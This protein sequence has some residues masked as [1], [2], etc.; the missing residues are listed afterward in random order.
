MR[1]GWILLGLL[2]S[3]FWAWSL[4]G[5]LPAKPPYANPVTFKV[6]EAGV[7]LE[8]AIKAAAKTA[9]VPVLLKGVPEVPVSVDLKK[10][11]F[12]RF[13]DLMLKVYAPELDYALLPEGVVLI[14][15]KETIAQIA[16]PPKPK[17]PEVQKAA[18]KAE[19]EGEMAVV[20]DAAA[21]GEPLAEAAKALG[22]EKA[23]YVASGRVLVLRGSASL[24]ERAV[25]ILREVEAKAKA[26]LSEA[27][28][29]P[30]PPPPPPAPA[31]G[32]D[33]AVPGGS[34]D[35]KTALRVLRVPGV[36]KLK[37]LEKLAEAIGVGVYLLSDDLVAVKGS[38]EKLKRLEEVLIVALESGERAVLS[39]PLDPEVPANEA[40]RLVS[41]LYPQVQ[42]Q[43]AGRNLLVVLSAREAER[44]RKEISSLLEGLK[45]SS[46]DQSGYVSKAYPIYGDPKDIAKGLG[47]LLSAKGG[48]GRGYR[49]EVL[50]AQ[51]SV[52][53]YGPTSF[54][55][56]VVAFLR[57]ADPPQGAKIASP[58]LKVR[59][60]LSYLSPDKAK[61]YLE[62][63]GVKD[64]KV[65]PEEGTGG[66]WLEGPREEVTKAQTYLGVLDQRPSQVKLAVRV[67]QVE[68]SALSQ[69]GP[70]VS[71][72]LSGISASF[73][74]NGLQLR[75]AL[76]ANVA[77]LLT[78]NLNALE[79][80]GLA[81][82]LVSTE[83]LARDGSEASL[84]SGGTLYL[85]QQGAQTQDGNQG[86]G[87]T[88]STPAV[89]NIEYGLVVRLK[90]SIFPDKVVEIQA[91]MELGGLPSQGPIANSVDVRKQKVKGTL[92][93][94]RGYTGVLGGLIY[95]QSTEDKRGIPILSAIPI[96]GEF[97]KS[98]QSGQ[99]E[100]VLLAL[101]TPLEVEVPELPKVTLFEDARG[102]GKGQAAMG[103][104]DPRAPPPP[105]PSQK[106]AS[107]KG[108]EEKASGAQG[109][110]LGAPPLVVPSPVFGDYVLRLVPGKEGG[111]LYVGGG[112]KTAYA[113]IERV[114]YALPAGSGS[115][116]AR[117]VAWRGSSSRFGNGTVA[118]VALAE[119]P[120]PG[121]KV[122][123]LVKSEAGTRGYVLG[124]PEE[125]E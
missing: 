29:A 115:Y 85:V 37:G 26:R 14:A 55:E 15:P 104:E 1:K 116:Q 13:L 31:L 21:S 112:P 47:A 24:L 87:T 39:F 101:I 88:A 36:G 34:G 95:Q 103:E 61:S 94:E 93:L 74:P 68:R 124:S 25:P 65:V 10:V 40:E 91:E 18:P 98:S 33:S 58:S 100:T 64:V 44:A 114:Y 42:V 118:V 119:V 122:L 75:Y 86:G 16:P 96:I 105:L 117:E 97:F 111:V 5:N 69:L 83:A 73:T 108:E 12:S 99:K 53:V 80:K 121:E 17:E 67:Y 20:L 11:P 84:T 56:E 50:E 22:V 41:A 54:H 72:S 59:L 107:P 9:G 70:E 60:Q 76:P 79:G 78:L 113:E 2:T 90:S 8:A 92:R 71:A 63:L 30:P 125:G 28:S 35:E 46:P 110:K 49:V 106:G 32:E 102:I 6:A 3:T 19:D 4:A 45:R 23:T 38:E 77:N 62:S 7:T 52:L 81:K 82:T 120:K 51:K 109:S 27:P 57:Q 43:A 66:I 89:S 48:E 123:L